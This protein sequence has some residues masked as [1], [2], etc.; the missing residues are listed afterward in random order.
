MPKAQID[1]AF[2]YTNKHKTK[3]F[4]PAPISTP[5]IKLEF[6]DDQWQNIPKTHHNSFSDLSHQI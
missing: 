1:P 2:I 4:S 6:S 5:K 3:N